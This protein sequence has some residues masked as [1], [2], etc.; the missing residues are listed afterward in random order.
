MY[1]Y[2]IVLGII[3][4]AVGLL[5]YFYYYRDI[6]RGKTTPH[7][8]SWLSFGLLN[9]ITFFAQVVKG[10]GPGAWV[11]GVSTITTFGIAFLAIRYGEKH[12]TRFDWICFGGAL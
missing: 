10:G 5:G 9:A 4:A 3:A 2:H 12:I 7:L 8:F 6:F 1:D 11:T